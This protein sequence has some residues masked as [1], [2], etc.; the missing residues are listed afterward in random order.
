[1]SN[2]WLSHDIARQQRELAD[3]QIDQWTRDVH[4]V[5]HFTALAEA[6]Q[7]TQCPGAILEVGCGIGHGREILDRAGIKYHAYTGVDISPAAIALAKERYPES[8]WAVGRPVVHGLEDRPGYT[9]VGEPLVVFGAEGRYDTVIDGSCVLHTVDWKD[10]VAKLCALSRRWVI[11]HRVPTTNG[12]TR[13]EPT[14]GYG[15]EFPAWRFGAA[16]LLTEMKRSGFEHTG[17]LIADGDSETMTF[18]KARHF[19]TYANSAYLGRLRA[20]YASMVRHCGPFVLHCLSWDAEVDAWARSAPSVEPYRIEDLL[21]ARKDLALDAL[22]GPARTRVEHMWTVGPAFIESAM[23]FGAKGPVTYV[24]A[25]LYAFSSPEP[26]FAEIGGAPA[27][28]V[29]HN[30]ARAAQGLPGPTVETHAPYGLWNVGAIV[31]NDRAVVERW[32]QLCREWCAD[33]VEAVE[34]VSGP[35]PQLNRRLRY[36]DQK[37][38]E[39]LMEE[40]PGIVGIKNPAAMA[41][42]WNIHTRAWD[43]RDGVIHFGNRPLGFFHFSAYTELPDGHTTLSRPEYGITK[44]QEEIVYLPYQLALAEA[45]K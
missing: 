44:R 28:F 12:E 35:V 21:M 29:G 24:D 37:Y 31:F 41:G 18:A 3:K 8:E 26:M 32:A 2:P 5:P 4:S 23:Y 19:C 42:P 43:V 40:F 16:E 9:K 11:L 27:G 34:K 14:K 20:L 6:V 13:S 38:L 33:R 10:H 15:H 1:M 36:G 22:P 7:A 17:S 25:D 45:R 39:D 30:F